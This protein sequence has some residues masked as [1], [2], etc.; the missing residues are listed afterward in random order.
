MWV[1]RVLTHFFREAGNWGRSNSHREQMHGRADRGEL[2]NVFWNGTKRVPVPKVEVDGVSYAVVVKNFRRPGMCM[3]ALKDAVQQRAEAVLR[4]ALETDLGA[5]ERQ[6][7]K[8]VEEMT[9]A[10]M[11]ASMVSS[12]KCR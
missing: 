4:D 6:T 12:C 8:T 1:D 2:G 7:A 9:A 5:N 11:E 10:M 3:S